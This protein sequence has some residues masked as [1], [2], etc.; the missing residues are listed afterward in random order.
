MLLVE[1]LSAAPASEC[2]LYMAT[3][4]TASLA[5]RSLAMTKTFSI[6]HPP[7]LERYLQRLK[8]MQNLLLRSA[9][10]YPACNRSSSDL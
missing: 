10:F 7:I 9:C 4:A 1:S 3:Q 6:T 8:A 5:A 2:T